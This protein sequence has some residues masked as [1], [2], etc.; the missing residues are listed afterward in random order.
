MLFTSEGKKYLY[1][2][3]NRVIYKLLHDKKRGGRRKRVCDKTF[4][5]LFNKRFPG[6]ERK[7]RHVWPK[8]TAVYMKF[9]STL[10]RKAFAKALS[11]DMKFSAYIE[12]LVRNDLFPSS[13]DPE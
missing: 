11:Q 4:K 13:I 6:Y 1:D 5:R 10:K 9:N 8:D 12:K 3:D 7:P 2:P